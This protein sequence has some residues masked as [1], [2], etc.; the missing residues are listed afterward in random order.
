MQTNN[1]NSL[2]GSYRRLIATVLAA[3]TIKSNCPHTLLSFG[4][5]LGGELTEIILQAES[6]EYV[7][8]EL[9]RTQRETPLFGRFRRLFS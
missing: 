8:R 1:A 4:S 6:T 9:N 3:L 2:A 7:S 5:F